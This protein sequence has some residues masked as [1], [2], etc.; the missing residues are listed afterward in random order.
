M[1]IIEFF[2]G[3]FKE[4]FNVINVDFFG[5]GFTWLELLLCV[6]IIFVII[7][8]LKSIVGVGDSIAFDNLLSGLR[9]QGKMSNRTRENQVANKSYPSSDLIDVWGDGTYLVPKSKYYGED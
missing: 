2:F 1:N 6:A 9:M 7:G 5:L 3:I 8:F 4:C